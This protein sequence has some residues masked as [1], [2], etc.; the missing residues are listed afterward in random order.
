M[1]IWLSSIKFQFHNLFRYLVVFFKVLS[2]FKR[3]KMFS[4][5]LR[6]LEDSFEFLL[7]PL[8][9]LNRSFFFS[10]SVENSIFGTFVIR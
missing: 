5:I 9:F 2:H 3:S 6:I 10:S 8:I 7:Y 4:R 1:G